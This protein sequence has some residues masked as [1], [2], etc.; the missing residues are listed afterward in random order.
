MWGRA[1]PATWQTLERWLGRPLAA[2]PSVDRMV[3]RYLGAF[4]PASVADARVWSG[5][6]GLC[7]VFDRVRPQLRT[8]RSPAGVEL[9]DLDDAPRPDSGVAAPV[10]FLPEYDN[11]LLS[12]ADRTKVIPDGRPVPLPPGDGARAGT[13]L[14]DGIF[15]ATWRLIIEDADATVQ[16]DATPALTTAEAGAVTEEGLRLLELLAPQAAH[17]ARMA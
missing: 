8:F 14:V 1:A 4:G 5:L 9:F 2:S 10:R 12:H 15:R 17:H 13:V 16:V 3:V 7:E 11:L 6:P